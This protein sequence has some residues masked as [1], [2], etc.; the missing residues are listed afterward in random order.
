MSETINP[1]Q[2]LFTCAECETSRRYE[3]I[4]LVVA[5]LQS[6]PQDA[7]QHI[8]R[9]PSCTPTPIA[10]MVAKSASNQLT[11]FAEATVVLTEH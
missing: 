10:R 1:F 2:I 6:H 9:C 7:Y 5:G 8:V 3:L 11:Q 4:D